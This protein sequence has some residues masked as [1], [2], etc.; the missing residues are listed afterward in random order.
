MAVI[1]IFLLTHRRNRLL[2]RAFNS[3]LAQTFTDWVC[4]LHND[5]PDDPF[6]AKL[7][8]HTGDPRITFHPHT[9]NW[10]AVASFNHVFAG[11][12][13]PFACLLE[14]DNWWEPGFLTTAIPVLETNP[15]ASLVWAN[16][17]IWRELPAGNWSKTGRTV[18]TSSLGDPAY[19]VFRW[20]EALQSFDALHSNG[21]MVFRPCAFNAKFVPPLTPFAII[22]PARERAATGELLLLTTPQANFALTLTTARDNDRSIWLQSKLLL[23]VSFFETVDL[24]NVSLAMIW[25]HLRAMTP[26]CTNLIF[27]TAIALRRPQLLRPAHLADCLWF[28]LNFA[29]HPRTNLRG[30]RFRHDHPELWTWLCHY[31]QKAV[32]RNKPLVLHKHAKMSTN[33]S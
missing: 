17:H 18:W 12:S 28:L 5:D 32:L 11:G 8:A 22:E 14:D 27:L 29:R 1:R 10:G 3:M 19:R 20:P 9:S 24:D 21:A 31:S 13:E 6:P 4:E 30:L 15:T 25:D 23:S 33:R 7:V 26:R 16:M 2:E